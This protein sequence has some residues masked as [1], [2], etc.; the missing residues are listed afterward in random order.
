MT[1]YII[2]DIESGGLDVE[3]SPILQLTVRNGSNTVPLNG[4]ILFNEYVQPH[5][6]AI[7]SKK[8]IEVNGITK[9]VLL[10]NKAMTLTNMCENVLRIIRKTF[11]RQPVVWVAY[12]N[13]GF[14]QLMLEHS[15]NRANVRM[16]DYWYFMDLLPL[17]RTR[18]VISNYRLAT[19]H[20]KLVTRDPDAEEIKLHNS[21]GDTLCLYELFI[22]CKEICGEELF[23]DYTR[24]K[25]NSI[26]MYDMP[27]NTTLSGYNPTM[28]FEAFGYK[29]IGD[30][31][32]QFCKMK[33][34]TDI[35][36]KF[37]MTELNVYKK[38]RADRITEQMH[39]INILFLKN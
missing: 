11:G 9:Q 37:L 14:D 38:Y 26:H 27:L 16:P 20:A 30:L 8:A 4:T 35:F 2:Y 1:N 17:C 34:D 33:C 10:D 21:L 3:K 7:I 6:G 5:N 19:V 29:T 39:I 31:F 18:F 24:P 36:V 15:F 22:A 12:N 32:K 25:I 13:F 23:P 28:K